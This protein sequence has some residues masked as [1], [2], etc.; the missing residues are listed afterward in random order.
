ML[1]N[2][3]LGVGGGL[4]VEDKDMRADLGRYEYSDLRASVIASGS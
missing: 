3:R 4:G 2:T 1:F